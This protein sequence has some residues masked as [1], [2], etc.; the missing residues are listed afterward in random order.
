MAEVLRLGRESALKLFGKDPDKIP[1]PYNIS[2]IQWLLQN[3][4]AWAANCISFQGLIDN[5]F[6][7]DRLVQFFCKTPV[8]FLIITKNQPISGATLVFTDASSSGTA[9]FSINGQVF[10]VQT[11]YALAQLVELT[12]IIEVVSSLS[13]SPFNLYTDSSYIALSITLLE[14]VPYIRPS[15]NASPL[16]SRHQCLILARTA[17]FFIGH[18]RAH[19]G[20]PGPLSYGND[21]VDRA[22][23]LAALSLDAILSLQPYKPINCTTLMPKPY[24][25]GSNFPEN[26]LDK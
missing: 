19:S 11:C 20:L 5:H 25:S 23:Q 7:S 26:R 12:A 2:Q 22:T 14:T 18:I 13:E 6:P 4:D 17:P 9:A 1:V 3:S 15:T 21:L 16:F 8:L 24:V 10:H